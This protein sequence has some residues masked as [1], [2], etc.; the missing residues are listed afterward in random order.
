MTKKEFDQTLN[1]EG[2]DNALLSYYDELFADRIETGESE[3][4]IIADFG[5]PIEIVKN[6]RIEME[7]SPIGKFVKGKHK[8]T[9]SWLAR[10]TTFLHNRTFWL[11]YFCGFIV[12]FPLTAVLFAVCIGL[13]A[14]GIGILAGIFAVWASLWTVSGAMPFYGLWGF[15]S[16][17]FDLDILNFSRGSVAV[18][19]CSVFIGV[20][21]F[22]VIGMIELQKQINKLFR[23]KAVKNE[24]V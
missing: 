13:C 22:A 20:G 3:Q 24:K 19:E 1:A 4:D 23:K 8:A 2:A 21:I 16:L 11:C 5:S 10:H 14:G 18:A 15:I 17:T 12:T 6:Y 9:K 7:L